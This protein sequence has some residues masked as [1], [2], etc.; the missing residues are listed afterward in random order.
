MEK[1]LELSVVG[2][3]ILKVALLYEYMDSFSIN[4]KKNQTLKKFRKIKKNLYIYIYIYMCVCVSMW[5][6]IYLYIY[7]YIYIYI[8]F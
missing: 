6:Y 4:I 5:V 7:I 2:K 3:N 8:Y 1:S